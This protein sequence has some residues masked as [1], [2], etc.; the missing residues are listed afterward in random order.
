MGASILLSNPLLK[1]SDWIRLVFAHQEGAFL[2]FA[3]VLLFLYL[4]QTQKSQ[5]SWNG[6]Y[7]NQLID[8]Y[9]YRNIFA[10]IFK[11]YNLKHIVTPGLAP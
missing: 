11:I 7:K 1:G 2:W 5:H 4:V 6:P 9:I 10:F 8:W 3:H